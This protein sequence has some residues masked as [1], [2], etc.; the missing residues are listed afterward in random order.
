VEYTDYAVFN[1]TNCAIN[2]KLQFVSYVPPKRF[3]VYMV[4]IREACT[5][6]HTF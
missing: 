1:P 4:I 2:N 3:D 5:K 6:A